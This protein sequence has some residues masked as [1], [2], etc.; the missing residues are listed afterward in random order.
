MCLVE[1]GQRQYRL[2]C[3]DRAA[4]RDTFDLVPGAAL[5][6]ALYRE[7]FSREIGPLLGH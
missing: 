2:H 3:A 6:L 7:R 5:P 4:A 1:V